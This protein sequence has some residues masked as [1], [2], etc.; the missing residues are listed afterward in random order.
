M[1]QERY[2]REIE[3]ILENAGEKPPAQPPEGP[4]EAPRRRRRIPTI[5]RSAGPS[6]AGSRYR[7][8]LLAGIGLLVIS[9]F[10]SWIYFF[11][12]GLALIVAA[13]VM[14]YRAPR[15]S[16]GTASVPRMWRGRSV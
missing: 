7:Y 3:E 14:Y 11:F 12:A 1:S 2:Q 10:L 15:P 13:Y 16:G 5:P 8:V 6:Q 9:Y 4:E